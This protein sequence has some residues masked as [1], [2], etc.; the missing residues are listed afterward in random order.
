MGRAAAG[1]APRDWLAGLP[2]LG[3]NRRSQVRDVE[4]LRADAALL[5]EALAW[6]VGEEGM[7]IGHRRCGHV[8]GTCGVVVEVRPHEHARALCGAARLYQHVAR[9]IHVAPAH[10]RR[11]AAPDRRRVQLHARR[12]PD[13]RSAVRP[14]RRLAAPQDWLDAR[15]A[16]H[17]LHDPALPRARGDGCHRQGVPEGL[18]VRSHPHPQGHVARRL[19][20]HRCQVVTQG[21]ALSLGARVG[22]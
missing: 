9:R 7:G 6:E 15:G 21:R 14:D 5:E 22:C 1:A 11:R 12:L 18:P 2:A 8:C 13:D 3:R 20:L 16:S 10:G 17:R 4:S 19:E